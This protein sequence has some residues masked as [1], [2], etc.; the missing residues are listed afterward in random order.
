M[1][2][3]YPPADAC[4]VNLSFAAKSQ[5]MPGVNAALQRSSLAVHASPRKTIVLGISYYLS[6]GYCAR[7]EL[8]SPYRAHPALPIE[9]KAVPES[10]LPVCAAVARPHE[11]EPVAAFRTSYRALHH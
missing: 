3:A 10:Y 8:R 2:G 11:T 5:S 9:L 6:S 1:R 7:F 4:V